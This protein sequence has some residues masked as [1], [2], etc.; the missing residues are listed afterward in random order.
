MERVIRG[1]NETSICINIH[2]GGIREI[3]SSKLRRSLRK[4][5]LSILTNRLTVDERFRWNFCPDVT[6][7]ANIFWIRDGRVHGRLRRKLGCCFRTCFHI[8]RKK[9]WTLKTKELVA[10]STLSKTTV[11]QI[12]SNILAHVRCWSYFGQFKGTRSS[13]DL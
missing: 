8:R 7:S 2:L 13:T 9:Y 6:N 3:N 12:V 1:K 11:L 5:C 10:R 4:I